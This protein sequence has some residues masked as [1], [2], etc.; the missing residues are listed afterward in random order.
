MEFE[1][2]GAAAL[3]KALSE[4]PYKLEARI[5]RGA[6]RAGAKPVLDEAQERVPVKKGRLKDTLRIS[7]K[8]KRGQ[9]KASV[10]AGD[11]KKGGVYYAHMVEGGTKAHKIKAR[12]K[13]LSIGGVFARSVNHPGSKPRPFMGPALKTKVQETLTA[14]GAYIQ[15]RLD[16]IVK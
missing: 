10:V 1:I 15:K 14:V 8:A 2:K 16:K 3:S 7:T 11:K 9:V 13:S 5:L 6:V 4:L 12:K